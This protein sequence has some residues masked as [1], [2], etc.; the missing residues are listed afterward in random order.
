MINRTTSPPKMNNTKDS[1]Q[2]A[3]SVLLCIVRFVCCGSIKKKVPSHAAESSHAV[4]VWL[5]KWSR[6]GQP[7]CFGWRASMQCSCSSSLACD[8]SSSAASQRLHGK[9]K[10][11]LSLLL[12]VW[13][14]APLED[15]GG[16][17]S[18]PADSD[19]PEAEPLP[20]VFIC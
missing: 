5:P 9:T 2:L 15:P 6:N 10:A 4:L 3:I 11:S 12:S 8:R 19:I 17:A 20:A 1:N 14:S 7:R 13:W 18:C 16:T